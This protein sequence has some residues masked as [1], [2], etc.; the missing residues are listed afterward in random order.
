MP[1][2]REPAKTPEPASTRAIDCVIRAAHAQRRAA[3][4]KEWG[5]TLY[6]PPLTTQAI[7]SAEERMTSKYDKEH[8]RTEAYRH[9]RNIILLIQQAEMEDGAPAFSMGDR[10]TLMQKASF[11]TLQRLITEMFA[12]GMPNAAKDVEE[13]KDSSAPTPS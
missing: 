11:L 13:G 10:M 12:A 3:E 1:K 9:E 8:E 7:I 2:T 5:I 6:F 4:V